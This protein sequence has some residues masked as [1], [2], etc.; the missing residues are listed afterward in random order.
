MLIDEKWYEKNKGKVTEADISALGIEVSC[1]G[2]SYPK[3]N[4][5]DSKGKVKSLLKI[6]ESSRAAG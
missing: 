5:P 2:R 3:V 4:Q 1:D 6:L